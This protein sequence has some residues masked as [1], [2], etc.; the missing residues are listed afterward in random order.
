MISSDWMPSRMLMIPAMAN[1]TVR[2]G[3]GVEMKLLGGSKSH[4]K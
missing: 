2:E 1:M 4:L 3:R